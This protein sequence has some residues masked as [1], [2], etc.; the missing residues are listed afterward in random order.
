[1]DLLTKIGLTAFI[2]FML[3]WWS[4]GETDNKK[5]DAVFLSVGATSAV[6]MVICI[7]IKIWTL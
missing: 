7:L 6:T 3:C 1:M 2:L 4:H 5:L